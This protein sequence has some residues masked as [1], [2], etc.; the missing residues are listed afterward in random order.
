MDYR[1][2]HR[3]GARREAAF[4]EDALRYA[5]ALWER[6]HAGRA[7]LAATRALYAVVEA[8]A[9]VLRPWPL[10]YAAIRWITANHPSD[11]FP[12]NPRISYQHQ[13]CRMSGPDR[14]R[15]VARAW[16]AWALVRSARPTLPGDPD[17]ALGKEPALADIAV[18]LAAHGHPGEAAAWERVLH[19]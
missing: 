2:L 6:G 7:L 15:R 4:Y 12:G 19:G 18:L 8:D 13:A 16:A 10:P 3:H 5:H 9:P 11:H 1:V 17:P 14:D